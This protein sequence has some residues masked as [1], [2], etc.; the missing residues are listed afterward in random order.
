VPLGV[1]PSDGSFYHSGESFECRDGSGGKL[2][3][4][5]LND[6]YCDCPDGSDEPGTP[7]CSPQGRFY[8]R[9]RGYKGEYIPS[10]HVRDGICGE[11]FGRTPLF[12]SL[13]LSHP[14]SIS[15]TFTQSTVD[16]CD[17]SDEVSGSCEN[18]CLAKGKQYRQE[19]RMEIEMHLKG[20]EKRGQHVEEAHSTLKERNAKKEPLQQKID[21]LREKSTQLNCNYCSLSLSLS[22]L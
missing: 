16:C 13:S 22:P 7:A 20:A 6:D 18:S 21:S 12:L 19:K 2:R 17:G 14:P 3:W 4:S 15:Y 1:A 8:C 9:N 10:S 11:Y 5:Q